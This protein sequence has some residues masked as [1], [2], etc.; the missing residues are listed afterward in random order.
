MD[1]EELPDQCAH[2]IQWEVL[3]IVSECP[4]AVVEVDVRPHCLRWKI[5]EVNGP[6]L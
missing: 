5:S 2:L 4:V 3:G 6:L 1:R